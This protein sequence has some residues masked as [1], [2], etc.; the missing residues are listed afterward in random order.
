MGSPSLGILDA[1]TGEPV[2]DFVSGSTATSAAQVGDVVWEDA[3]TLLATITQGT[4]QY[5]V[6][7]TV[8]G[9]VERVAGP[10]PAEM[11]VEYRFATHPFG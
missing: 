4:E 3:T 6:R 10:R 8:D 9:R 5:V 7:A 1:A 11:S 2:V